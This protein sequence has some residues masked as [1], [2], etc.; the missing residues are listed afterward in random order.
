MGR[1]NCSG[2]ADTVG[3]I[4]QLRKSQ[5]TRS[6]GRAPDHVRRIYKICSASAWRQAEQQG[7]YRG[8]ADDERDG[9]I[10]LSTLSQVAQTANRHFFGQTGLLL[11][12]VDVDALGEAVRWERSR[13][14][15]LFP[16]L[17]GELGLG[18]VSAVLELRGR[19]DGHHEIPELKS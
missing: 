2:R 7:V 5:E 1:L 14:G 6:E 13:N 10:H 11:I 15:E 4:R 16:H 19:S 9:F 17:Y 18:A 12:E 8:S 3:R